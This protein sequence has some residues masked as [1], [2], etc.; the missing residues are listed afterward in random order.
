MEEIPCV[1]PITQHTL[2]FEYNTDDHLKQGRYL[3]YNPREGKFSNNL[4]TKTRD[5]KLNEQ[6]IENIMSETK[7]E[8]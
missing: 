7:Q 4:T 5:M 6:M 8:K 2:F 1:S 3:S